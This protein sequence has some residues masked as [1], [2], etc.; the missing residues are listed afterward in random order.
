MKIVKL[1]PSKH[2]AG[3]WLAF[4]EDG[5]ILRMGENEVVAFGLYTGME[6]SLEQQ[7]ELASASHRSQVRGKAL[8]LLS[9][10][11]L[12]R[13]ELI[14]KLTA[15]PRDREK[16]PLASQ[17]E[18]EETA[19]WLEALG[20]LDD[21]AYG[22]RVVEHYSAKG[23]GPAKLRDE[24]YRRGV[25][26]EFWDDALE[27][28]DD[29]EAGIDAYLEKKLRG[30]TDD[31]KALKRAADGLMRRGYRWEDIKDRLR[32]YGAHHEEEP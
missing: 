8:D 23:Y 19:D 4:L 12:S 30:K 13:R 25:P 6:L 10:R 5:N 17:E 26:R 29:P 20:Y 18:A 3:R 28:G 1:E 11:P 27:G 31:P 24:L 32:R 15:Q 21:A 14:K 16:A 2:K 22:R 9:V 7:E